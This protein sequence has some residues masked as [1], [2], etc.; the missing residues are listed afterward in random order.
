VT[1]LKAP[2]LSFGARG[3]ISKS[4][5]FFG[6]KGI[7]CAREYVVPANPKTAAQ[8]T[9]RGHLEDAVDEWHGAVYTADD[10]TAWNRYAGVL[11]QIMSGFNAFVRSFIQNAIAGNTWWRLKNGRF[12]G[13]TAS[14]FFFWVDATAGAPNCKCY[15]GTSKTFFPYSDTMPQVDGGQFR[16]QVPG[17]LP[18]TLYYV[19]ATRGE[20]TAQY[21]RT[22]IYQV[23]TLAA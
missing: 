21:G 1:K 2:L 13:V 3:A 16:A 5:V 8:M 14:Q 15:V 11:A 23:R 12:T 17:L 10:R 19:Y 7:D 20:G 9:Q 18:D 4:V 6:W 22:G